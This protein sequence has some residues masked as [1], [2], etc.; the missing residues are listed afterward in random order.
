LSK[1]CFQSE[2]SESSDVLAMM[3]PRVILGMWVVLSFLSLCSASS[4]SRAQEWWKEVLDKNARKSVGE[5]CDASN[6][7]EV[8]RSISRL[9]GNSVKSEQV[10]GSYDLVK[11][12]LEMCSLRDDLYCLNLTTIGLGRCA[13]CRDLFASVSVGEHRDELLTER[14]WVCYH[15]R[16]IAYGEIVEKAATA[17]ILILLSTF[18]YIDAIVKRFCPC[19]R[20]A[21]GFEEDQDENLV[22]LTI[23]VGLIVI[24]QAKHVI[25]LFKAD[26]Y[27]Y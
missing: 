2:I 27:F 7:L 19:C 8:A 12:G 16:K 22:E 6:Q 15:A 25:N 3:S 23:L 14:L 4:P 11:P 20:R 24:W 1:R 9:I 21:N 17:L 18:V 13:S 26:Y 5:I 10:N